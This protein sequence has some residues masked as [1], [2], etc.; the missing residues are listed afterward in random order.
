LVIFHMFDALAEFERDL[1]QQRTLAGLAAARARG[2]GRKWSRPR[3]VFSTQI[4]QAQHMFADKT[5]T[6]QDICHAPLDLRFLYNDPHS[7]H[8]ACAP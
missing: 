7:P 4:L 6:V 8:R 2:R 3:R 5:N 1:I